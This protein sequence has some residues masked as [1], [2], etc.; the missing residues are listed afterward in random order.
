MARLRGALQAK[1]KNKDEDVKI[2]TPR[3]L[4]TLKLTFRGERVA[5]VRTCAVVSLRT[6]TPRRRSGISPRSR[7]RR[8]TYSLA[9]SLRRI[10][11][12]RSSTRATC[13]IL[14]ASRLAR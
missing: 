4:E 9:Y 8:T 14:R 11:R 3:N 2:H 12:T 5:K 6:L 7:P 13:A 10:T 1:Y